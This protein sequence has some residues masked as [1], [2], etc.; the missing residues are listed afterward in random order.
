MMASRSTL[1]FKP[2]LTI[3]IPYGL[4]SWLECL[5][6][7]ILIEGP[8][9]IPEFI[10]AYCDELLE[11][12]ERNPLMD[13]KDVIHLYQEMREANY[14]KDW[15]AAIYLTHSQ[16]GLQYPPG[17][18][19]PVHCDQMSLLLAEETLSVSQTI[20]PWESNVPS[21]EPMGGP[22]EQAQS[23]SS[24]PGGTHHGDDVGD[25][26]S[27]THPGDQPSSAV[28]LEE[29][30]AGP[31]SAVQSAMFQ[32]FPSGDSLLE[33]NQSPVLISTC[34]APTNNAIII[35]SENLPEN[36]VFHS[37]SRLSSGVSSRSSLTWSLL[38]GEGNKVW[39][40][41]PT[42]VMSD[43]VV[44]FHKVPS[45][46]NLPRMPSSREVFCNV[47]ET[48]R[49]PSMEELLVSPT[50][51][52][53]RVSAVVSAARH[54]ESGLSG[55]AFSETELVD[56]AH[57][58]SSVRIPS[59]EER[60]MRTAD[61]PERHTP[62]VSPQASYVSECPVMF[63]KEDWCV[64]TIPSSPVKKAVKFTPSEEISPITS[65]SIDIAWEELLQTSESII[66]KSLNAFSYDDLSYSPSA[67]EE[68][69]TASAR[70]S[71]AVSANDVS[72][73]APSETSVVGAEAPER[74]KH[75][76]VYLH[77]LHLCQLILRNH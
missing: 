8:R 4:K 50:A 47:E 51:S 14:V 60:V 30:Q 13:T 69:S 9:Q 46:D 24:P 39:V 64:I 10:A 7:A 65:P 44:V 62:S 19:A 32:R 54:S 1:H 67:V 76:S 71:E 61:T 25:Q 72:E 49:E 11:F 42:E 63:E 68:F 41:D 31:G 59:R 52:V 77:R 5:C 36:I 37:D 43:D 17:E 18:L 2:P 40:N 73:R 57:R 27:P 45:M 74:H 29:A 12:R 56:A 6:R 70:C 75:L 26:S 22:D 15:K 55:R 66:D 38:V 20:S 3:V 58:V 23:L 53:G 28:E 35:H 34:S 48:N 16:L 33:A 21:C